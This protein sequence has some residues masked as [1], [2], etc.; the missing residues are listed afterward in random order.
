MNKAE[1]IA[2]LR[3]ANPHI[4]SSE[5][6][7]VWL[8]RYATV[9]AYVDTM[10]D[11]EVLNALRAYNHS[12][13]GLPRDLAKFHS[14]L[15]NEGTHA[16]LQRRWRKVEWDERYQRI[17]PQYTERLR[18]AEA[19]AERI[20]TALGRPMPVWGVSFAGSLYCGLIR[21][22]DHARVAEAPRGSL[23]IYW[24][25]L[26]P[27]PAGMRSEEEGLKYLQYESVRR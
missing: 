2:A 4:V 23:D 13:G 18:G 9:C 19:C 11:N 26:R 27:I 6:H 25:S 10:L 3:Q 22:S 14:T 20:Y 24:A 17:A 1:H 7:E 8:E 21:I 12:C 15:G 16:I 5:A